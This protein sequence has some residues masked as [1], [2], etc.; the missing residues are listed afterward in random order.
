L[1]VGDLVGS[2]SG[3]HG[4]VPVTTIEWMVD[5]DLA[6][7]EELDVG[8]TDAVVLDLLVLQPVLCRDDVEGF[9]HAILSAVCPAT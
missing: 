2:S 6:L 4:V 7:G 3:P 9:A 8:P 5:D 1:L